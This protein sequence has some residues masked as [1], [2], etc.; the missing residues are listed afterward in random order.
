M[1][2]GGWSVLTNMTNPKLVVKVSVMLT[3]KVSH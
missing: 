2:K 3:N 1:T